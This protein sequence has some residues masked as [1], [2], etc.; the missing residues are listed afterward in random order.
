M[1]NVQGEVHLRLVSLLFQANRFDARMHGCEERSL[2]NHLRNSQWSF[3]ESPL[4]AYGCDLQESCKG[5]LPSWFME[6]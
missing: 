5:L 4:S 6:M 2:E 1:D 3:E